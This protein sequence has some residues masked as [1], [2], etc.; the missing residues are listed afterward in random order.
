[1]TAGAL[2][3][4]TS[5]DGKE[6]KGHF[7]LAYLS[8]QK[9]KSSTDVPLPVVP[10]VGHIHA[11]EF[12]KVCIWHIQ[13]QQGRCGLVTR[14]KGSQGYWEGKTTPPAKILLMESIV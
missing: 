1:M 12:R 13:P 4:T 10:P 14:E 5:K 7:L 9:G 8:H 3:W 6:M 2:N 11:K